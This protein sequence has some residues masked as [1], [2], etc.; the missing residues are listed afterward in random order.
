MNIERCDWSD[1]DGR[2]WSTWIVRHGRGQAA[3]QKVFNN[4][5]EAEAY[6]NRVRAER[7]AALDR[8]THPT[9]GAAE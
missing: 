9:A 6:L 7:Q 3:D 2:R 4:K 8:I 5:A 1:R